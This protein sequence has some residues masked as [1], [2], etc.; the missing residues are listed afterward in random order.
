LFFFVLPYSVVLLPSVPS[1]GFFFLS[2]SRSFLFFSLSF[3][4]LHPS[5]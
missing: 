5:V 2:V 3:L 1:F 4:L